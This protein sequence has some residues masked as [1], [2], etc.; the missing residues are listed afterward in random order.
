MLLKN[1]LIILH[2][3]TLVLS[4]IKLIFLKHLILINILNVYVRLKY[5]YES[6]LIFCF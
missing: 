1:C 6:V 4:R 2:Y 3:D 5:K